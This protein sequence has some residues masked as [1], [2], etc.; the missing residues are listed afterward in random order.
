M[1]M[2]VVK[3]VTKRFGGI[4]AVDNLTFEVKRGEVLGL[5]GPN[6]AGKSTLVNLISGV[7]HS[8]TG[9]IWLKDRLVSR[10]RSYEVGRI[11]I[12]RTFQIV[13]PFSGMTVRENVFVGA[14]FGRKRETN[15]ALAEERT[16]HA[17]KATHL[18]ELRDQD[19][20]VTTLGQRKKLEL[21]RALATEPE[22]LL[23]DEVMAGLSP[24][25]MQVIMELVR[26][27]N[28]AG[29]TVVVIEHV[30]KAIMGVSDRI[31]VLQ[32]GRLIATGAPGDI[33]NDPVVIGA[34]LGKRYKALND[35]T[36]R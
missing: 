5:I 18:Y 29:V 17:L 25:E 31:V 23:L 27:I 8:D 16:T 14:L 10:M 32:N 4:A 1:H 20:S 35:G 36:R 22:L 13:K 6:G 33:A 26:Q 21:A 28:R 9:E 34:Y 30:M 2:L 3:N 19:V 15:R 7:T 24:A 12:A 11:G